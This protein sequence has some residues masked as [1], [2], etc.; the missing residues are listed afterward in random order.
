MTFLEGRYI[1][2]LQVFLLYQERYM[3]QEESIEDGHPAEALYE[4]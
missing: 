4:R 3:K 2:W 1:I